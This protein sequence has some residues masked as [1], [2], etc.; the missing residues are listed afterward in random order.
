MAL[1]RVIA[2]LVA[3]IVLGCSS[4]PQNDSAP[5]IEPECTYHDAKVTHLSQNVQA[6]CTRCDDTC[7]DKGQ[8]CE[9]YGA[10]CDFFGEDGVCVAC[11]NGEVG[12]LHCSPIGH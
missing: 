7:S 2:L 1:L 5:Y 12:E 9:R 10:R 6:W 8:P 4:A 11:C 3:T